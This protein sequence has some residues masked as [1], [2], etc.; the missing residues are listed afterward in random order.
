M[1]KNRFLR[2]LALL[3]CLG[4]LFS[5]SACSNM[6]AEYQKE[7]FAMDTVMYL[8]AYGPNAEPGVGAGEAVIKS[9]EAMLDPEQETS[10]VY[11][12]NRADGA[13]VSVPGQIARMIQ[14]AQTVYKQSNKL[15]INSLDLTIYP[16]VKLWGFVDGS[17][18]VPSESE[19]SDKRA[20]LHFDQVVLS[21]F[22]SSG[23]YELSMPAGCEITFGAIA[24]GCTA[25]Y[26]ID[27][28]RNAGVSSGI[29]SL[30]GNVQTLGLKPDGSKWRIGIADPNSPDNYLGILT[31]GET[32]VVTSGGYQRNFTDPQ[33][34]KT[35]HHIID[36]R[37]GRPCDNSLLSV[38][39]ICEDGAM[40]DAL[41]TAL[42]VMGETNAMRYWRTY[43]KDF[44][45][46]LVTKNNE[47]V[48][49]S[50][51]IEEFSLE[52]QNYTLSFS[53]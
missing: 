45:M 23:S 49:T 37:T 44:Q 20:S 27:A 10:I 24:K 19:I 6:S 14:T 34:G 51:L 8:T 38:T 25:A 9:M 42:F 33:T 36:P 12:L 21:S 40:A 43:G 15:G 17:Y 50:G 28:M 29:I 31:A 26:V 22:P 46:I 7:V 11:R 39:V 48:C 1:K 3:L 5:L 41:S 2:P 47:V 30:G 52:N 13:A 18:Y 32:A 16:L 53:E 35:Y 4:L